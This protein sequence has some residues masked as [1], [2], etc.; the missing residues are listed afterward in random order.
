MRFTVA[1]VGRLRAPGMAEACGE[2]TKRLGR[3]DRI[4][5]VEVREAPG[6]GAASARPVES[7]ALERALEKVDVRVVLDERGEAVD[8]TALARRLERWGLEGRSHIGF[9]IGGA[10]GHS[11]ELR[12]SADWVWSLGKLTLPHEL[13]RVVLLEQ[14]YRAGTIQR[15]EPYHKV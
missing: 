10:W 15:G 13:V 3:T 4:E 5:V 8:S 9:A 2:Y 12:R 6:E 7:A 14:L 1:C 11:D